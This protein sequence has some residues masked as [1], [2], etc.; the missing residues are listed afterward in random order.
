[1]NLNANRSDALSPMV[2]VSTGNNNY[3]LSLINLETSTVDVLLSVDDRLNRENF[4]G[5][6]PAVPSYI[7]ESVFMDLD[8]LKKNETNNSIFRR[9][10]QSH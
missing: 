5:G 6:I 1:M 2:L 3:E 9:Y 4:S 10:L 8:G 7:R